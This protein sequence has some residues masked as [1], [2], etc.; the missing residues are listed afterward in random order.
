MPFSNQ[1]KHGICKSECVCY[2]KIFWIDAVIYWRQKYHLN[3]PFK[4]EVEPLEYSHR[5]SVYHCVMNKNKDC[6]GK[7]PQI[8]D[9]WYIKLHTLIAGRRWCLR[10][11]WPRSCYIVIQI[12]CEAN[13]W[14]R[15]K[16]RI[17]WQAWKKASRLWN[18][19]HLLST[20]YTN[21]NLNAETIFISVFAP[22]NRTKYKHGINT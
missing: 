9:R 12:T 14:R 22:I 5:Q 1:D 6:K 15:V 10:C 21:S 13:P 7:R 19:I 2:C 18:K 17:W 3:R 11:R 8:V 20:Q 4:V 16:S